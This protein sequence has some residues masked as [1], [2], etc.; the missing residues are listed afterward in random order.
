M[1]KKRTHKKI[2]VISARVEIRHL[3]KVRAHVRVVNGKRIKV[4]S[5]YRR[6]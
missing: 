5:H 1:H 4:R 6:F 2:V 3:V